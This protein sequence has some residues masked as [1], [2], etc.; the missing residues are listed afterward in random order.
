MTKEDIA[1][2]R[3]LIKE[4]A[5][6]QGESRFKITNGAGYAPTTGATGM[7]GFIL[8][9]GVAGNVSYTDARGV[10]QTTF[11][12]AGYHPTRFLTIGNTAAGTVATDLEAIPLL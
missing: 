7:G 6:L 1:L 9:V 3:T 10:A 2:I 11:F 5:N 12:T 4:V 8:Y